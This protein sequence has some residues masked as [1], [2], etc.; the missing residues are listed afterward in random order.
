MI[1]IECEQGE[2]AWHE[3]RAGAITA[4]MCEEVRKVMKSGARKGQCSTAAENY[5]FNLAVERLKGAATDYDQYETYAMRRGKELEHEARL[6]HEKALGGVF[7]EQAGICL[8]DDGKFGFSTDGFIGL[9]GISEYKCFTDPSKVREILFSAS[10]NDVINQVQMGLWITGRKWCDFVLYYPDLR[11]KGVDL[12]VNRI[13]RDEEFIEEM[14]AD[15][16]RFDALVETY[17][18]EIEKL[19]PFKVQGVPVDHLPPFMGIDS[20]TVVNRS[21]ANIIEVGDLF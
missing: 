11:C 7:I 8:T 20:G 15:L 12:T 21:E 17:M 10:T 6:A 3:G 1:V 5:A 13:G 2:A 16:L 19:T 4:S 14:V 18:E 9:D